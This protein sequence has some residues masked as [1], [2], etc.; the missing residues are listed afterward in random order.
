MADQLERKLLLDG[1]YSKYGYD[2]RGYTENSFDRRIEHLLDKYNMRDELDL[3]SKIVRDRDFFRQVIPLL[4]ISTTEMFRDPSFFL[5]FR[6]KSCSDI[7][8]IS[9]FEFLDRRLQY[10]R[11]GLQSRYS[12]AGRESV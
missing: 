7:A 1:I 12:F 3:L 8:N 11:G 9:G 2:F 10:R 4:S 5:S 6:E